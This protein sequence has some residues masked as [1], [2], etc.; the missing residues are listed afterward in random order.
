MAKFLNTS[1]TTYYLEEL[2]KNAQERLYLIS[3]YLKLNDRV[4]ELLEDKD[5]M[6]IDVR[7]VYGKSEL[8]PSEAAW[9]KNLNYVRTSYCP[10]LHA[11][12]YVSEDACIITSLN[13]YEFS[14]VNN[15]EMGILLKR[16]EDGE[17]YQDAYSEAQRIIRISDEVK[18]SVDV[19]EKEQV[20]QKSQDT[21][22][23]KKYDTLTVA[24]LAEKW[25]V[26][27][28]E[29]N[30]KLC[31]AGLQEIDG[32][33]YRLT[34]TGKKAGGLI[35]KGRYGYFIVWPDSLTLEMVEAAGNNQKDLLDRF[36]S[37]L[38]S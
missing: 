7:I 8:Q 31:H 13:L 23:A 30:A 32:K 34:D 5:R 9:L 16:S 11:K 19:V 22:I 27:T 2:I 15:N 33:F 37:W 18:I 17:V 21:E 24:K 6:K 28:E 29:C 1:G 10:N 38:V 26:T 36:I 3:P 12:C 20:S 14:Q 25:G 4:K 35:K